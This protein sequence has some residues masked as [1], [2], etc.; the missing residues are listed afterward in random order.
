[1]QGRGDGSSSSRFLPFCFNTLL[2][3]ADGFLA[4]FFFPDDGKSASFAACSTE[5]AEMK[6]A[7]LGGGGGESAAVAAR[8]SA[9]NS[10]RD[11]FLKCHRL[12]PWVMTCVG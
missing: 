8:E 12:T 1:M 3:T 9:S 11:V 7:G 6:P 10:A 2:R 4:T 5:M